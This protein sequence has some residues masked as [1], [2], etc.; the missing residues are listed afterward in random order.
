MGLLDVDEHPSVL[1]FIGMTCS[2][3]FS[4]GAVKADHRQ[5]GLFSR[6]LSPALFIDC[7]FW[8]HRRLLNDYQCCVGTFPNLTTLPFEDGCAFR[9][10]KR[11]RFETHCPGCSS[12]VG[13]HFFLQV[14]PQLVV[15]GPGAY[16]RASNGRSL[17]LSV[18]SCSF[19]VWP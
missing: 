2:S 10:R 12:V 14:N 19:C 13:R 18:G 9:W 16:P 6:G 11:R 5:V 17:S 7:Q 8:A 4:L 3:L 15:P 1:L